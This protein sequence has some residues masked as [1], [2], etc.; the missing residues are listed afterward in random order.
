M[1]QKTKGEHIM[2]ANIK[3][4]KKNICN[5]LGSN[6]GFHCQDLAVGLLK[7]FSKGMFFISRHP[8]L[9]ARVVMGMG[10]IGVFLF[11]WFIGLPL[12]FKYP[13]TTISLI[14]VG[15]ATRWIC[16]HIF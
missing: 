7:L 11:I 10:Y 1:Y 6:Q 5:I 8:K 15:I 13:L 2:K 14:I 9:A 12:A 4:I 16:K 3:K